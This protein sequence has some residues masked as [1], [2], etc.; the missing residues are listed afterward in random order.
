MI[1][2]LLVEDEKI[3]LD[4]LRNYV[5]WKACG[6]GEI[7][8]ARGGRSALECINTH[9]PDI[10]ITDIQ[11][12]GM[13]GIELASII[14]EEGHTSKIVFLTGYDRFDYAKEA[15][16]L[17]ASEFLLK[18][19][20]ISEVEDVTKRLV[21]EIRKGE[22][23]KELSALAVGRMIENACYGLTDNAEKMSS[24]Y[25]GKSAEQVKMY[26]L[27]LL[28]V[29]NEE[30][31]KL[32]GLPEVIY[33]FEKN[34]LFLVFIPENILPITFAT[35][36]SSGFFQEQIQVIY[37]EELIGLLHLQEGC[38]EI[39]ACKDDVFYRGK[40]ICFSTKEHSIWDDYLDV[41]ARMSDKNELFEAIRKGDAGEAEIYFERCFSLMKEM[42][43]I[44][45]S[46]N[47]FSLLLNLKKNLTEV[48]PTEE[49]EEIPD[50]FRVLNY[51][52]AHKKAFQWVMNCCRLRKNAEEEK[53]SS[54]V[55]SFV[56]KH[57]MEDCTVEEMAEGLG[58]SPN[59]L[60]RKFKEE[61]GITILEQVTNTR[62]S[63]AAEMLLQ[64]DRKVKDVSL[65]VGYPNVSYFT[66][67]FQKKFGVR[68]NEYKRRRKN[69]NW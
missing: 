1:K 20:Q 29:S 16:R 24:F 25:F 51:N 49:I 5:N 61:T 34:A 60:R 33:G 4:T 8:T 14:R 22:A 28:N 36:M 10:I 43:R 37:R 58:V 27:A 26:M 18:P 41:V 7:Y 3:E 44:G 12:P 30:R 64:A 54:Y 68:P 53:W 42:K 11:M 19:F 9:E 31:I 63:A 32:L 35:R 55:K 50:M 46:Q 56:D 69:Q 48:F 23:E 2:L 6:I 45:F 66:Q 47:A 57:Y 67:I 15:I 17:Q 52:E 21:E 39:E 59:Y 38:T 65:A 62:L 13:T 40:N